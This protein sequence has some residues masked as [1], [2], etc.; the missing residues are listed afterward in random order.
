MRYIVALNG[1]NYEIEVD[2]GEAALL[3]VVDANAAP[4]PAPKAAPAPAPK[5]AI[6]GTPVNAPMPG[7]VM[8]ILVEEGQAVKEGEVLLIFEAMKMENEVT[9]P[10]GGTVSGIAVS[11]GAAIAK[12]DLLLGIK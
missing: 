11:A 1:K 4:A 7:T 5:R 3:S 10:V 9:A 8:K 2:R 12:D 6:E